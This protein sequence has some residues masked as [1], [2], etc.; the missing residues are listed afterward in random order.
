MCCVSLVQLGT[1]GPRT[2]VSVPCVSWSWPKQELAWDFKG[3]NDKAALL[4]EG[5]CG[6]M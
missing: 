4:S 2:M 6:Q 1:V 5:V 3:K